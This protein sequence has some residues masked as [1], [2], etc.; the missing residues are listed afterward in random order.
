MPFVA[1]LPDLCAQSWQ[2]IK[3]AHSR[4]RD[5]FRAAPDTGRIEADAAYVKRLASDLREL[6]RVLQDEGQDILRAIREGFWMREMPR[7]ET[8]AREFLDHA[9]PDLTTKQLTNWL[10]KPT[11]KGDWHCGDAAFFRQH[12]TTPFNEVMW[13]LLNEEDWN[14]K[15]KNVSEAFPLVW[16]RAQR[17]NPSRSLAHAPD[18]ESNPDRQSRF[19]QGFDPDWFLPA[20]A[21]DE[22]KSY[23]YPLEATRESV[24]QWQKWIERMRVENLGM[25][26]DPERARQQKADQ[27]HDEELIRRHAPHLIDDV[28]TPDAVNTFNADVEAAFAAIDQEQ[29]LD[30]EDCQRKARLYTVADRLRSA[31]DAIRHVMVPI[32]FDP[33]KGNGPITTVEWATV[34]AELVAG[35]TPPLMALGKVLREEAVTDLVEGLN[36]RGEKIRTIAVAI[37]KATVLDTSDR[38]EDLLAKGLAR[39]K[40]RSGLVEFLRRD[41]TIEI[42]Q[43]WVAKTELIERSSNPA[44]EPESTAK[45]SEPAAAEPS[46]QSSRAVLQ[47]ANASATTSHKPGTYRDAMRALR[48]WQV[49]QQHQEAGREIPE[50]VQKAADSIHPDVDSFDNDRVLAWEQIEIW[51]LENLGRERDIYTLGLVGAKVRAVRPSLT[52]EG[53]QNVTLAEIAAIL[54]GNPPAVEGPLVIVQASKP[55]AKDINEGSA[56]E[57]VAAGEVKIDPPADGVLRNGRIWLGGRDFRLTPDLRTLLS[58]LILNPDC[59]EDDVS[60]HCGFSGAPHL[61]K[62]LTD[63]RNH[64]QSEVTKKGIEVSFKT[65][66]RRIACTIRKK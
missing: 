34:E 66:E 28:T 30:D 13:R 21:A 17:R 57:E 56:H 20:L 3:T 1:N 39:E 55:L 25:F 18:R 9:R 60:R 59:H 58:Y 62:R 6:G 2:Q 33:I 12:I 24:K 41:L 50:K 7:F 31:L 44:S 48:I 52:D 45:N 42:W 32:S 40:L 53:L 26:N 54:Y 35:W 8:E 49:M 38:V 63:L 51:I 16:E 29:L 5:S 11:R 14:P 36:G 27:L 47:T 64:L 23:W 43:T 46:N 19:V 15:P 22:W 4:L 61:H 65:V 37:Y 10:Q